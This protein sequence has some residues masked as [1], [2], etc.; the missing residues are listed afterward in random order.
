M[1]REDGMHLLCLGWEMLYVCNW[2]WETSSTKGQIKKI[3]FVLLNSHGLNSAMLFH[4]KVAMDNMCINES[5]CVPVKLYL[6]KTSGGPNLA[7]GQYVVWQTQ[8]LIMEHGENSSVF[9]LCVSGLIS[10]RCLASIPLSHNPVPCAIYNRSLKA[11]KV[12]PL[13]SDNTL[14]ESCC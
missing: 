13:L 9:V 11:M 1:L 6:L 14:P 8:V 4:T 5:G 10:S 12:M 3:S 7:H 2:S